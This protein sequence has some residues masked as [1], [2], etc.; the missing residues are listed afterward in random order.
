MSFQTNLF[1]CFMIK[2]ILKTVKPAYNHNPAGHI[3][4]NFEKKSQGTQWDGTLW[5]LGN[6]RVQQGR[7]HRWFPPRGYQLRQAIHGATYN[8]RMEIF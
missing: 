4:M 3:S 1:P 8:K 7:N 5:N 2:S 6:K